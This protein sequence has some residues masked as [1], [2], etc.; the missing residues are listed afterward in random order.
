MIQFTSIRPLDYCSVALRMT[1]LTWKSRV[2][3][4]LCDR[5]FVET[6]KWRKERHDWVKCP[7]YKSGSPQIPI[8]FWS[9]VCLRQISFETSPYVPER[10]RFKA[11]RRL[12]EQELQVFPLAIFFSKSLPVILYVVDS[13]CVV[14]VNEMTVLGESWSTVLDVLVLVDCSKSTKRIFHGDV[15]QSDFGL[16]RWKKQSTS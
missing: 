3:M 9:Y 14:R 10:S 2:T 5:D 12:P 15:S 6:R 8:E 13:G 16:P 7:G 11:K 1:T 4:T